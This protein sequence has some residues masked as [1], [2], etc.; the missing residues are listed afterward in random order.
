MA[1]SKEVNKRIAKEAKGL[2]ENTYRGA[3]NDAAHGIRENSDTSAVAGNRLNQYM[4]VLAGAYAKG[5]DQGAYTNAVDMLKGA[6]SQGQNL[7]GGAADANA[8]KV[9]AYQNYLAREFVGQGTRA[10]EDRNAMVARGQDRGRDLHDF[11]A[12]RGFALTDK[13]SSLRQQYGSALAANTSRLTE[14]ERQRQEALAAA[15]AAAEAKKYEADLRNQIAAAQLNEL[16]RHNGAVEQVSA[17]KNG[18][19]SDKERAAQRGEA[20]SISLFRDVMIPRWTKLNSDRKAA[21]KSFL[22]KNQLADWMRT[23]A[24]SGFSWGK[25][26]QFDNN[27]NPHQV[28]GWQPS[29]APRIFDQA[30]SQYL[31]GQKPK[32]R[33]R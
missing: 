6:A 19:P 24:S 17:Y 20:N 12:N 21:G 30:L 4:K 8:Q 26:T 5:P 7:S 11:Y 3:L 16:I 15:K 9:G 25:T 1:F 22:D 2:T 18:Q 28:T 33:H 32:R 23:Q 27:N 31:A 29:T 10:A 14:A 13:Q